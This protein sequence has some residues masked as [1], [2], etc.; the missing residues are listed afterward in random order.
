[1]RSQR[2]A[3]SAR[4]GAITLLLAGSAAGIWSAAPATAAQVR[5]GP[6][7]RPVAVTVRGSLSAVAATSARNAWAVGGTSRGKNLIL[8][9]NGTRWRQVPSPTPAEINGSG[10]S[11]VA[12]TSP[13]NAWAVAS[14]QSGNVWKTL[15]LRWNGTRWRRVPSPTPAAGVQGAELTGVAATSARNAWAVGYTV[16]QV[17]KTVV[18][19]WNGTTWKRVPSPTPAAGGTLNAVA[20]SSARDAWAVGQ[21]GAGTTLILRWNGAAWKRVPSFSPNPLSA[22]ALLAGVAAVSARDAWAVGFTAPQPDTANALIL[23]WNG[24]SWRRVP[25]PTGELALGSVAAVSA[26]DAWAV[27]V[28]AGGSGY[29]R[30]L[31]LRWNGTVWTRVPSPV[32][33]LS[34]VAAVSARNAWAVGFTNRTGNTLIL[35]WNG[36]RWK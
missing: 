24:T 23:H 10:L 29:I 9:W 14:Y 6:A 18:L 13:C 28:D 34:G 4:L 1:M 16:A 3:R 2:A 20:A 11:G 7:G 5:S 19:R 32:G 22:G 25:S 31:I 27:G 35:R 26:R 15:T 21:T 33:Q 30:T 12:A 17:A 8:R 36:T